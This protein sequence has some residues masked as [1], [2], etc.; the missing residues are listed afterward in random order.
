MLICC[1]AAPITE[2][3]AQTNIGLWPAGDT[4]DLGAFEDR[5]VHVFQVEFLNNTTEP[6]VIENIRPSCGCTAI[7]W[8]K[9]PI[10][11][12]QKIELGLRF[13]CTKSGFVIRHLDFWLSDRKNRERLVILADCPGT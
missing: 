8:P 7:D 5:K 1:L 2:A 13:N 11:A 10:A 12:G 4:L 3:G 6:L 9:E